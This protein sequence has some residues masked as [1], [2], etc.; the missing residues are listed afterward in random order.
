MIIDPEF[1]ALFSFKMSFLKEGKLDIKRTLRTGGSE[2]C[3]QRDEK[4]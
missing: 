2:K 1:R 4:R 3:G